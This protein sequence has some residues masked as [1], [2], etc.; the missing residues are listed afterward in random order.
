MLNPGGPCRIPEPFPI[1]KASPFGGCTP[2]LACKPTS[3]KSRNNKEPT[4]R[5]DQPIEVNFND[6]KSHSQS[7]A[8]PALRGGH[9]SSILFRMALQTPKT[10][11]IG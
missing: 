5:V 7:P 6:I 1:I 8:S 2:H 4:D 11:K 9:F 3:T 10:A